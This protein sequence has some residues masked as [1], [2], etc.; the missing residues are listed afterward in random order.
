MG[1]P[2]TS[3][4]AARLQELSARLG[5]IQRPIRV[6]DALRW[7]ESVEEAFLA[8]H[9]RELPPVTA[10]TY[11]R[12][13]LPFDPEA[14]IAELADL[15]RDVRRALGT[16][17]AAG[18]L[19]V[20][21]CGGYREAC[22]LVAACGTPKFVVL[23]R[24]LFGTTLGRPPTDVPTTATGLAA[25]FEGLI[26]EPESTPDHSPDLSAAEAAD[27]LARR[28]ADYF[29]GTQAICVR[30][31]DKILADA[32]A[33]GPAL[34]VRRDAR[35]RPEM[36]RL[37]E[38]HEG[39]VHL[40]TTLNGRRQPICGFL[41]KGPPAVT[42]TQEGLAVLMEVLARVTYPERARRLVRRLEAVAAAERGADFLDVYRLFL[43]AGEPPRA[44]YQHAARVFRGSL[45]AGVGPCTKDLT[46][47]QGAA[48]VWRALNAGTASDPSLLFC[49]KVGLDDLDDLAELRDA[50]LLEPPAFVPAPFGQ[51]V[52]P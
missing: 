14:K 31:C 2:T 4:S 15:E 17:S 5:Q 37:L 27:E 39:W 29:G 42:R 51:P 52:A 23:S 26:G 16:R 40:G 21:R 10:D 35:F 25:F 12:R 45:P 11:R 48:L 30:L 6:L 28:L 20:R 49:G 36:V 46:Y 7:D 38:V 32:V 47:G 9:G 44:S 33:D 3:L 34:K 41:G 8:A 24:E 22:R 18:R 19:L 43:D 50:G 1:R 13:P